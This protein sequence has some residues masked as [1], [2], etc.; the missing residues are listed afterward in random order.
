MQAVEML[1]RLID[2]NENA[3]LADAALAPPEPDAQAGKKGQQ[4]FFDLFDTPV[5]EEPLDDPIEDADGIPESLDM[6]MLKQELL[7]DLNALIEVGLR[8]V[9]DPAK[10]VLSQGVAQELLGNDDAEVRSGDAALRAPLSR[11]IGD[12]LSRYG[13]ADKDSGEFYR[14]LESE[15][16]DV[17][18]A[19]L[20]QI[21]GALEQV[22]QARM[23]ERAESQ[24][25]A[26]SA[27]REHQHPDRLERPAANGDN[28]PDEFP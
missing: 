28:S 17:V 27:P 25:Q 18:T 6:N 10:Q 8:R 16:S 19:G 1:D 21:R 3:L 11:A 22:L 14:S 20:E 23:S 13:L 24:W 12:I 4:S 2:E 15:L 5:D 9:T 7:A 26:L